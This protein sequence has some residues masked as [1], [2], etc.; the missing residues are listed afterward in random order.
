MNFQDDLKFLNKT[1]QKIEELA[2][3]KRKIHDNIVKN[4]FPENVIRGLVTTVN[5]EHFSYNVDFFNECIQIYYSTEYDEDDS[6]EIPTI[7]VETFETPEDFQRYFEKLKKI[8]KLED[9]DKKRAEIIEKYVEFIRL[10]KELIKLVGK[11]FDLKLEEY[12]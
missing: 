12:K 6:I 9:E 1:E 8:R 2:R 11:E 4:Y 7:D 10:K 5:D 3:K